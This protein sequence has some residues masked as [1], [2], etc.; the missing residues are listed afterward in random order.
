MEPLE[1]LKYP[2]GKF[3]APAKYKKGD[4]G[5]CIREI[6]KL[7]KRL[8][9]AVRNLSDEQLDTPYRQGGWTIR[10]V[11]HHLAD[12]HMNA[13]CR[14]KLAL[15]EDNPTVKPYEEAKWAELPDS[16]MPVKFSLD[17]LRNLHKRWVKILKSM[18]KEQMLLTFYHPE[19]NRAIPLWEIVALYAWHGNHHLAHIENLKKSR[20]WK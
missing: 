3:T 11:V 7:P 1:K 2:V 20:K 4:I 17:I 12:S 18:N 8:K 19:K 10:Q 6:E 14:I 16:E 9:E 15:T 5:K 13:Y